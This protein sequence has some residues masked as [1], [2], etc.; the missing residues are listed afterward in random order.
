MSIQAATS[1]HPT[2]HR[3]ARSRRLPLAITA[4]T[5]TSAPP[6]Q[7]SLL[8]GQPIKLGTLM[9][10]DLARGSTIILSACHLAGIGTAL[11][12]E[13]LGFPAAML[14]LGASSVIA[15]LWPVPDSTHTVRMMA[16][17]HEKLRDPAVSPSI[18][19]GQA[20]ARAA[21][22]ERVRPTV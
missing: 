16:D 22:D 11:S 13:Q 15:A 1:T 9:R 2:R 7:S 5:Y 10:E 6:A 14:A 21:D 8:L 17:L 4:L 20:V 12:G 18:A 3:T 19:L